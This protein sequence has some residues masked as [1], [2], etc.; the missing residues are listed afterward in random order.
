MT[1]VPPQ[2]DPRL[3]IAAIKFLNPAP[4]MWNFEHQ[5]QASELATRYCIDWMMPAQCAERLALPAEDPNAA[6]IGLVPIAALATNPSLRIIP[7]FADSPGCAIASKGRVRSILLVR[8]DSRP[9]SAIRTVA[10]DTSS[11]ASLA[12]TQILFRKWWNPSDTPTTFIPHYPDLDPMLDSADA[13]L[14]IG[15]PALYALEERQNR[16]ERTGEHLIYHDLAEEWINLTGVPWV[17]AVWAIRESAIASS[18]GHEAGLATI[19]ADLAASRDN[20]LK[21]IEALVVEWS[22]QL[23][24]PANTI[25]TY[26]TTNI[27]YQLDEQCLTGLNFFYRLAAETNVLPKFNLENFE[28]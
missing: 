10:A 14:L 11:R 20:G 21:N 26:L 28:A 15:D 5:P 18:S 1:Q 27:F 3:R 17:S 19:A 16:E 12:Y 13:A 24:I 2:K 25:R 23:P 9:L 4:L 7:G 6:D 22:S 8:R